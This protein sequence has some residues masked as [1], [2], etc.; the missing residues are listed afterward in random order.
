[1]LLLLLVA[2]A[3]MPPYLRRALTYYTADID[4]YTIF[5]NRMVTAGKP[6]NWKLSEDYNNISLA[7][8]VQ[9][10]LEAYR[11]VA[12]LVT[13]G[14]EILHEQYWDGYSQSSYSNSFSVAKSIVALLT[15]IALEE[16]HIKSLDDPAGTYLKTFAE[17]KNARLTIRQLLTMSS[18][19][20]WDE[21]YGSPFSVTTKAY[22]GNSIPEL[23]NNLEVTEPSGKEW[24]YLS[25][26]TQVL[27]MILEKV[28]GQTLSN[29]ASEKLWKPLGAAAPAL[30]SLD[31]EGG[32]EKAYCCFNSNARD[33]AR[34]GQLVLNGGKW[35]GKQIVSEE[36][37]KEAL[38]PA[39]HLT[40][41]DGEK[42]DFYGF[43]WWIVNYKGKN[44]PYA[45]GILGQYIFILE[46]KD[47]V[48]VRLGHKRDQEYLNNHP[49]DVYFYLDAAYSL[50]SPVKPE[51]N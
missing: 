35:N 48:V 43:Q 38:K 2:Y 20:D 7:A 16:G 4:D 1:M 51:H 27:A 49:K 19:L 34:I 47:A 50:L 9:Q 11:P 12:F 46:D 45:R 26:N 40:A 15:G 10:K 41:E 18:G 36:F 33:F 23:I 17:E 39:D 5:E 42:V 30:W 21:S 13:Q 44:I 29:Y 25:G 28:T 6:Q 31:R 3:V 37:L 14:G 8:P 22:Y 32:T 24:K